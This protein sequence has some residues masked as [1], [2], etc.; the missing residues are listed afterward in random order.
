VQ[1]GG[2]LS[3]TL[4]GMLGVSKQGSAR[5]S[6]RIGGCL[7]NL[8]LAGVASVLEERRAQQLSSKEN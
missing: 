3:S 7:F 2:N 4:A 1:I 8:A 5:R 6:Q